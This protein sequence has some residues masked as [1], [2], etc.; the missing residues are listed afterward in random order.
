[1]KVYDVGFGLIRLGLMASSLGCSRVRARGLGI[2]IL[3]HGLRVWGSGI[4]GIPIEDLEVGGVVLLLRSLVRLHM[5]MAGF[6]VKGF[7]F[8]I[9]G[10][11]LRVSGLP[12]GR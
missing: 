12:L 7:W 3:G 4:F 9:L 10:L 1:M 5:S 2:E 11:A 6:G 8:R